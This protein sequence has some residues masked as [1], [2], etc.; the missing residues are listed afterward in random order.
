MTS[1]QAKPTVRRNG[2]VF[3]G[4]VYIGLVESYESTRT[5]FR[6]GF[7]VGQVPCQRWNAFDANGVKLPG[8][9]D[10]I[11]GSPRGWLSRK[12]AVQALAELA[13]PK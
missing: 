7:C 11:F 9:K 3:I 5:G 6:R 13:R 12:D 4:D 8:V 10:A 2:Q 1:E